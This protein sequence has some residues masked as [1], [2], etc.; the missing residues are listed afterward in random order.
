MM[1]DALSSFVEKLK[2]NSELGMMDEAAT[3]QAILLPVLQFLGWQVFDIAE[4]Y[5]EYPVKGTSVASILKCRIE[6][7]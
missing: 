4:V 2:T 1:G 3:K 5:P 6:A 7:R